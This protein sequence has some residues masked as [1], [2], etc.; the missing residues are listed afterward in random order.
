MFCHSHSST[1]QSYPSIHPFMHP[2]IHLFI[3]Y[4]FIVLGT[5]LI[6]KETKFIATALKEFTMES[7]HKKTGKSLGGLHQKTGKLKKKKGKNA[8]VRNVH[9]TSISVTF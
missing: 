7:T 1:S 9:F 4:N 8:M 5:V 6:S 3:Q 2:N